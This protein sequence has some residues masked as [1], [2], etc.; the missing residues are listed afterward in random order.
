VRAGPLSRGEDVR[1]AEQREGG[2]GGVGD[3]ER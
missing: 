1:A 3:A 2:R